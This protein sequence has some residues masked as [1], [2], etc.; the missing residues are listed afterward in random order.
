MLT[1]RIEFTPDRDADIFSSVPASPAVFHLRGEDATAEPY[2]SKTANLRRRLQRLL[3]PV[4]ERT[5]KLNLRD[6]VRIIEYS[7]T[8][9]DFESGFLLYR[10]LRE[11]FPKTYQQRLRFRFAPFVKLHLEN[12]YPRASITTRLGRLTGRSLFYGPFVSRVA[13]EK[14]MN[15]SLDFFK[16]RRCVDDLHPDPKFPGCIYSE[17]KMCLAPCFKGCT[18]K[19]Y[20]VEVTRVQ[21]YFDSRGNSLLRQFSDDREAASANLAFEDAAV[22]HAKVEKLKPVLSQLPEIVQRLDQLS[23]LM[24]QP[25]HL[26]GSVTF[27]RITCGRVSGPIRFTIQPAEHAKSQSMEAR[28]QETLQAFPADIPKSA[29]ETMEHVALLKRWFYRG[30][31]SGEIFLADAKGELPMRRVVRGISRVFRGENLEATSELPAATQE[32]QIN[33]AP[34]P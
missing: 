12:E 27:F 3:G 16:M 26:D 8:G 32:S 24:I 11:A 30:T 13:A 2:V 1:E 33:P 28:V 21:T 18:D 25:S 15:D 14:F 5:K 10:I 20:E 29:L 34:K 23:A 7:A 9:S 17:M 6:R 19:E 4:E 31:R 22:I